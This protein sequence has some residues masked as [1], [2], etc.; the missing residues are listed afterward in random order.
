MREFVEKAFDA[1]GIKDWQKYVKIDPRYKR[2]A[3]VPHLQGK[4]DKAKSK[5]GW[6][7]KVTFDELVAMMVK[8]DIN[9][10]EDKK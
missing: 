10:Y 2:P 4:I 1:A 9:R 8:A 5:L 7:P 3:E 6:T